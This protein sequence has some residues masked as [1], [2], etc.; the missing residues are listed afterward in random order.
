MTIGIFW[1]GRIESAEKAACTSRTQK[2]ECQKQ[3]A[4]GKRKGGQNAEAQDFEK[5]L[6]D[7]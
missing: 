3:R 2:I 1:R 7:R 6:R 5:I 4:K